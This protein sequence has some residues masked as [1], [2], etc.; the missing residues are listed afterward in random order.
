MPPS[1]SVIVFIMNDI[2]LENLYKEARSFYDNLLPE[3]SSGKNW[4]HPLEELLD[5]YDKSHP[6]LSAWDLKA[7]QY[8]IISENFKPHL[9][10]NAPFYFMNNIGY[11]DGGPGTN[12]GGWLF[13]RNRHIYRDANSEVFDMFN[14]QIQRKIHLCCGPYVD[15]IHY[16]Y[17]VINVVRKGFKK[18]YEEA[19]AALP[20]CQNNEEKKFIK[21]AMRGLLAVKRISER[22]A[23]LAEENLKNLTDEIHIKNME[24]VIKAARVS[25]WEKPEHFLEGLNT[26]WFCREICGYIDGIGNSHLGRP[27]YTLI[28]IYRNDIKRGYLKEEEAFQLIK[29]FII[30]GDSHY[31]K[32]SKVTGYSDHELEMGFVL[33]GCDEN[34]VPVWNEITQMFLRAHRELKAIYPKLHLRYS[35]ES[36]KEY[37][38]E[39]S[40]DFLNGRSVAALINDDSVIPALVNYGV[41]IEDA[42][43]YTNCG[44]WGIALEGLD[45][46]SGGNYFHLLTILDLSTHAG[47][48]DFNNEEYEKI[49]V[50][51]DPFKGSENF[52]ELYGRFFGNLIRPLRQR[53]QWIGEYGKLAPKVNPLPL[54]SSC[55]RG[56]IERRKDFTAGGALYNFNEFDLAEFT[57]AIDGLLA[58]KTL[59]FDRKEIN[60][61]EYLKAVHSNWVGYEE[62]LNKVR[63]CK[64][65][66]DESEESIELSKRLY[67][68]IYNSTR[69][70]VNERGGPYQM[71]FYVYREFRLDAEKMRATAD[72]RR[73]GDLYAMGICPT[74][75]HEN[76]SMFSMVGSISVLDMDKSVNQS[77]NIQLPAGKM[78][79]IIFISLLRGFASAKL[80]HI[81]INCVDSET[82]KDAKLYP[83]K[84]QDLVV[85]VCGFSAKFVSL[86]PEWQD[87]FISRIIYRIA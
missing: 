9:L 67:N 15:T 28:D 3:W 25:P 63:G 49:G 77:V 58:I 27:D 16:T 8:E 42:R 40:N 69:D 81:Q 51:I 6:N 83:E 21:A 38:E 37:L 78:D 36:P 44:C 76:D 48:A 71:N 20:L 10:N 18:I 33:G 53:C 46:V 61:D 55:L 29:M 59:C 12:A 66:G 26:L 13:K 79:A 35:S 5:E 11:R 82:L 43:G 62:L 1:I 84:H 73:S 80:K 23:E 14:A 45:S 17:P 39:I 75:F 60:L 22:F 41:K 30:L 86:S 64:H 56:C 57:N 54:F 31:N 87:E 68:D 52:E 7:A 85:R 70:L 74:R 24:T 65:F 47:R 50:H 34:G 2:L 4:K 19:E 32:N 72:G